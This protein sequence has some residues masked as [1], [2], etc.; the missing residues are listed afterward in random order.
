MAIS[1]RDRW[2]RRIAHEIVS[3]HTRFRGPRS[4]PDGR[5]TLLTVNFNAEP[6]VLRLIRSYR[7][8]C[9]DQP[10]HVVENGV[11]SPAVAAAAD[12]YVR[13]PANLHHGLGLDW[14]MCSVTSEWTLV[15]DPDSAIISAD[16]LPKLSALA[17]GGK[18][19]A[20]IASAHLLYHPICL[21]FRTEF[22]KSGGFSFKERWPWFDVAGELTAIVGGRDPD[23]L[24]KRTKVAGPRFPSFPIYLIEVYEDVFTNTYLGARIRTDETDE[25]LGLPRDA[26]R[27]V[28]GAWSSW[29]DGVLDGAASP[30]ELP[31][32]EVEP[33]LS[34]WP[35]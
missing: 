11:R 7:K 15:C 26:V 24:L 14:G 6:E 28:H 2:G 23:T 5:T 3:K 12:R 32:P 1:R 20:G 31:L 9:P 27:P 33:D 34:G 10:A 8:F 22:W 30:H 13:T 16:F 29:V 19:V 21:L 35:T 25:L 18:G 4:E 17:V